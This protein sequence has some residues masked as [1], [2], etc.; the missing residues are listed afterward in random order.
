[1]AE[2]KTGNGSPS[3]KSGRGRR[4]LGYAVKALAPLLVLALGAASFAGLRATKPEMPQREAREQV[5]PVSAREAGF[6][7]FQPDIRLY[8][9]TIAGRKVEMR[10]LVGGEIIE[11][12][13]G[14][15]DGGVVS[16]GDLLLQIDPFQY[17]GA[18][19]EAEAGLAEARARYREIEATIASERDA[20]ER[21]REQLDI[22]RRDLERAQALVEKGNVSQQ[23]V[24][25]RRLTV[26]EREQAVEQRSSNLA[27]QKAKAKQQQAVIDQLEWKLRQARR[28]LEDTELRAPFDAYVNQ[29][30][31]EAGRIVSAN[32]S[33]ATLLDSGW[34]EVRFTL[35]N[36][37]YGRIVA[38]EG[39]V[40]GRTVEVLWHIGETPVRYEARI[41][42]VAAEVDPQTGGVDVYARIADPQS[43]VPLRPGA[44]VEVRMQ[45][46]I[47]ADVARLPNTALYG[48]DT[49]YVVKDGRLQSRKVVLVGEAG[50]D[51]LVRGDLEAG[52]PVMTTRLSQAEAGLRVREQ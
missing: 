50:D 18:V 30:S 32:D 5:R 43:P 35:T 9:R 28:E 2:R 33:V 49:V 6:S 42:R 48:T 16:K 44:F 38:H 11:I 12:G 23:V 3:R 13:E 15:K 29:T 25:N 45:D 19:V 24:D 1:M 39:D 36:T 14:L 47:Y 34:I 52:E 20:L 7:D 22:A 46:R 21:A 27:V 37:Q 26:S 10:A 40:I 17:E 4:Y 8:G 51:I 31:A 41:E